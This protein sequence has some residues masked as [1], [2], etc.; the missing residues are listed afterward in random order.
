MYILDKRPLAFISNGENFQTFKI[1]YVLKKFDTN[2][3]SRED[4]I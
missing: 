2:L 3:Q 4:R 1:I